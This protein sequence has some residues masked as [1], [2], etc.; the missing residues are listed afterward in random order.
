MQAPT[1]RLNA[2]EVQLRPNVPPGVHA[3]KARLSA[4]GYYGMIENLDENIGRVM[5][6]LRQHNISQNTHILFFSDHGEQ[7][8][9]HG[10]IQKMC[11]YEE[12]I[13]VPMI[14]SGGD[15]L[16]HGNRMGE[17]DVQINH[18]DI[19]PTSL[20]LCGLPVPEWM[21]GIDY[22]YI[23]D[24]QRPLPAEEPDA[25]YLQAPSLGHGFADAEGWRGLVT[26]DGW[27]IAVHPGSHWLLIN[28]N[29]DPY[30]M[31]NLAFMPFYR[32]KRDDMLQRLKD[33]AEK[34][35]D[36]FDFPES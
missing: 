35:G 3:D 23:R 8:G 12:S 24:P 30:E 28:L 34:V 20:G 9:S 33:W 6:K 26:R 25:V 10:R 14:F 13:S 27:K 16:Y 36:S 17:S 18:V 22:S 7:L 2:S 1:R 4:P 19:A 21:A 11:P 31:A 29:D 32:N 5:A 15:G